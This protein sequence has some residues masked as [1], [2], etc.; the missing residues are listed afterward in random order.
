MKD[1]QPTPHEENLFLVFVLLVIL[2]FMGLCAL[3]NILVPPV[4]G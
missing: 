3:G 1:K 2:F 4:L